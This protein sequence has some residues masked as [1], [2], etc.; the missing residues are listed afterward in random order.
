LTVYEPPHPEPLPPVAALARAVWRGEKDLLGLLP[1]DA[2]RVPIGP[3]GYT[4]RSI[5]VVN[6]PVLVRSVLLDEEGV[7]PKSDLMVDALGPLVGDSL[8]VSSGNTWHRQRAMVDPGFTHM[9]LGSAFPA[10]VAALSA[11][12][13]RLGGYATEGTVFSLDL[14]MSHLTADIICRTVF[15]TSLASQAAREVFDAFLIFER[16]AAQVDFR[17]LIFAPAFRPVPQRPEVLAA[18]ARIRSQLAVL[19]APHLAGPGR[20]DDIAAA[21]VSARDEGS[22]AGFSEEELIDQLGVF[23]LAGHE[24]TASALT[25]AV[26]ILARQPAAVARLRAEVAAVSGERPVGF[27]DLREL[28]FVR[29]V[30]R[31][32][33]RLYPPIT[34]LPRVAIR[35]TRLGPRRLRRGAMVMISPWTIHRHA[36]LWPNPHAFDPDR[37]LGEREGE[38]VNGAYLPFGL[39]PRVCVGAAFA[40]AEATLILAELWRRFDFSVEQADAVRPI[41]RLTTRPAEQIRVRVSRRAG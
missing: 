38:T 36:D 6:D 32:T 24:T 39:G 23:F 3:L 25:W 2:Y 14:A 11:Y 17:R 34:F 18:C 19:L 26:Y 35:S 22:G 4:R 20:F 33:L 8:F 37:F 1:A 28:R 29:A 31:E 7:Y 13:A 41:A 15:S 10:M 9:R 5:V 12:V 30:F 21:M 16:S 40:Q 27:A